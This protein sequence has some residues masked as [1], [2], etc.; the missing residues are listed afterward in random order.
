[1]CLI[2]ELAGHSV[3]C[4]ENRLRLNAIIIFKF[5]VFKDTVDSPLKVNIVL[6]ILTVLYTYQMSPKGGGKICSV[7][8]PFLL[9]VFLNRLSLLTQHGSCHFSIKET[10]TIFNF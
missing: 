3:L 1:M 7:Q 6:L 10:G 8:V 9:Q 4:G 2:A 5:Y